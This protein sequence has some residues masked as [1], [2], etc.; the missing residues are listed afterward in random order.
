L[1]TWYFLRALWHEDGLTQ[2]ELSRRIGTREPTTMT[3][4]LAMERSGLVTRVRNE[5][6][7]R[8]QN[9]YLTPK[10]R[11]L[12]ATLLPLA[13]DVVSTATSGFTAEEIELTLQVLG[14]IQAN[15]EPLIPEV[16]ADADPAADLP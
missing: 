13:Q 11:Q 8:K 2:R 4:I 12:K 9:I 7:R 5:A 10:A 15:L 6:D 14:R 1:G 16:G 3:A